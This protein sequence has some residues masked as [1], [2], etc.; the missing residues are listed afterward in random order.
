MHKILRATNVAISDTR[1]EYHAAEGEGFE[2][3]EH[4]ATARGL[5]KETTSGIHLQH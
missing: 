2:L 5:G 3:I 4:V 1:Y